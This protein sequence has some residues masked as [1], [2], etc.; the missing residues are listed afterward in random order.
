MFGLR[1]KLQLDQLMLNIPYFREPLSQGL[2]LRF[3]DEDRKFIQQSASDCYFDSALTLTKLKLA[4]IYFRALT[5][6][7]R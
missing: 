5:F 1:L 7:C 4:N 2:S 3:S 6:S